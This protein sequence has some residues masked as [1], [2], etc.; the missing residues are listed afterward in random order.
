MKISIITTT[1]NSGATIKDTLESILKQDHSDYELII[2]DGGSEDD[3]LDICYEYENKFNGRIKIISCKDTSLYDAMNQGI[4]MATGEIVGLLNSDDFYTSADALSCISKTFQEDSTLD[5]IYGDVHYVNKENLNQCIRYYSSR[6]FRR[7]LIRLGF[8]PAHP[9]FYCKKS[10]Y[11]K[12]ILSTNNNNGSTNSYYDTS[13]KIAGDFDLCLRMIYIGK[14]KTKYVAKDFVTMRAGGL[15][16]SGIS[17]HMQIFKEHQRSFK[18]NGVYTN[19]LLLSLRYIYKT[20]ELFV[21]Q[22]KILF[23]KI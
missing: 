20:G 7:S 2:K 21:G 17:S 4:S 3:T 10:T 8:M 18:E 19:P 11:D 14:I 5:A 16:S 1:Y 13:Y 12:F 23:S 15:S 6:I 22:V 9:S